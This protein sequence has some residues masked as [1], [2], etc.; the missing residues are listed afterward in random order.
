MLK[1]SFKSYL[2]NIRNFYTQKFY[3]AYQVLVL[4]HLTYP[5][6]NRFFKTLLLSVQPLFKF[7]IGLLYYFFRKKQILKHFLKLITKINILYL[8]A[9]HFWHVRNNNRLQVLLIKIYGKFSYLVIIYLFCSV[10]VL[11]LTKMSSEIFFYLEN[12]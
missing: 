8:S 5:Y 10:S 12:K 7:S 3:V 6:I 4:M 2:I 1:I 9:F 11:F